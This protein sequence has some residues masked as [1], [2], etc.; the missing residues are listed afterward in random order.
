[1]RFRVSGFWSEWADYE[2]P[3]D[4]NWLCHKHHQELHLYLRDNHIA[5]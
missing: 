2:R 3:Y 5:V 4:V 1:M